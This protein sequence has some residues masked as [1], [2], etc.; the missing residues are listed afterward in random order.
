MKKKK[1]KRIEN[2]NLLLHKFYI[3]LGIARGSVSQALNDSFRREKFPDKLIYRGSWRTR[4]EVSAAIGRSTVTFSARQKE[5]GR[6]ETRR[7][8]EVDESK[9][10]PV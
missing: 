3:K 9:V 7:K 6:K 5:Q 10:T 2:R 1:K 8:G 4:G